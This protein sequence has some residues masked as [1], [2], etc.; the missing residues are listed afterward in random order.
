MVPKRITKLVTN[1]AGLPCHVIAKPVALP[2]KAVPTILYWKFTL[3]LIQ[4]TV[5]QLPALGIIPW[6]PG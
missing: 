3:I 1:E 5:T 2:S 4:L 6:S